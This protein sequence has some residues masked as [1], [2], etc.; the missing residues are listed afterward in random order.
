MP[1]A[2][3]SFGERLELGAESDSEGLPP[4]SELSA[5]SVNSIDPIPPN[6]AK[7]DVAASRDRLLDEWL[8][9]FEPRDRLL[10]NDG[11]NAIVGDISAPVLAPTHEE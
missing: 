6:E 9:R 3:N 10:V 2:V 1:D 11:V 7:K 5:S 4:L 8:G